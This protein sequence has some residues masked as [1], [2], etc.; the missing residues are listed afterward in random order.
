M[1]IR[2][3]LLLASVGLAVSGLAIPSAALAHTELVSTSPKAGAHLE[4]APAEVTLTFDDELDPDGSSFTVTDADGEEVGTGEVD[5]TVADRN[6]LS[7]AVTI[8]EPGVYGV[9][10]TATTLDGHEESGTFSFGYATGAAIPAPSGDEHE[11]SDTAMVQ[12]ATPAWSAIG[13]LL[14]VLAVTL[15]AWGRRRVSAGTS[16]GR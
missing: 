2:R 14:I 4:D 1:R 12:P 16:P 8:S 7:G 6:V 10:W 15:G 5:L 9:E 13:W 3:A 11:Q